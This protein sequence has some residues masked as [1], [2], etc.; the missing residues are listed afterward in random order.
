MTFVDVVVVLLPGS[1]PGGGG[2]LGHGVGEGHV[3]RSPRQGRLPQLHQ[4]RPLVDDPRTWAGER[5]LTGGR[6]TRGR[7][8]VGGTSGRGGVE[9]ASGGGRVVDGELGG[10]VDEDPPRGDVLRD[11]PGNGRRRHCHCTFTLD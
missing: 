7:G 8:G 6:E 10:V 3:R 11:A 4:G 2:V 5:R 9:G 1:G